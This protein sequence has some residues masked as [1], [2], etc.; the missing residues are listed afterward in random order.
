MKFDRRLSIVATLVFALLLFTTNVYANSVDATAHQP[1]G[2]FTVN[3]ATIISGDNLKPAPGASDLTIVVTPGDG[4]Q[5]AD[6]ILD[7]GKKNQETKVLLDCVNGTLDYADDFCTFDGSNVS[8]TFVNLADGASHT[9]DAYF[10]LN[11][12]ASFELDSSSP[13]SG[14][15]EPSVNVTFNDTSVNNPTAWLWNF[16]DNDNTTSTDQHPTFMYTTYGTFTVTL[17]V[18]ND[19]GQPVDTTEMDYTV[20]QPTITYQ[21]T[22]GPNG[23]IS[24][25]GPNGSLTPPGG[26]YTVP[27]G[28]TTAFA[29]IP[30]EYYRVANVQAIDGNGTVYD[31]GQATSLEFNGTTDLLDYA[32]SASFEAIP[33]VASFSASTPSGETTTDDEFTFTDTS[34]GNLTYWE[35]YID[36]ALISTNQDLVYTF[37]DAG[38]FNVKLK[39]GNLA[40]FNIIDAD[41]TVD[42]IAQP[43][44]VKVGGTGVGYGTIMEAYNVIPTSG[45]TIKMKA[46]EIT[47]DLIFDDPVTFEL[48]GG[49]DDSFA[50]DDGY[51]K[52]KGIVQISH[53]KVIVSKVIIAP[54]F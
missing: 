53:G 25:A 2:S 5:I 13:L 43:G 8:Y 12:V 38:T 17:T 30:D 27:E 1:G 52:I 50:F 41:Y 33:I 14:T 4:Y 16:G 29:I 26:P 46:A 28:T 11:P 18:Y 44:P 54:A 7:Q 22:A 10:A 39:T 34:V 40:T 45:E 9:M 51:T 31:Y 15:S 35:W 19:L 49:Y 3:G 48:K 37:A 6:I 20:V 23:S 36:D 47:E 21:T 24:A 42:P 32:I